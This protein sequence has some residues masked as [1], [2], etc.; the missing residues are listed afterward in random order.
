MKVIPAH[1]EITRQVLVYL[2]GVK[3]DMSQ[4]CAILEDARPPHIAGEVYVYTDASVANDAS[5][6]KSTQALAYY[7]FV[8]NNVFFWH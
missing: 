1:L 6:R 3:G 8:N 2:K 7:L 4:W 5:G